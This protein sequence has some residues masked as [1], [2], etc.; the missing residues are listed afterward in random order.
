MN[1]H[2]NS[3]PG[4]SLVSV[5]GLSKIFNARGFLGKKRKIR[6]VDD[7][8]LEIPR[9]K[10]FGLVGESGCGKTTLSRCILYLETPSQGR[11]VIDGTDLSALS[12][13]ALRAI[14]RKM[15]IVFQDPNSALNPKMKIKNSISEGLE[16]YGWSP[17]QR[18]NRVC[19][20]LE[21]V[22]ISPDL[23]NRYP[24]EFSGGQRQRIVIARA[25]TMNPELLILDE[26][27]SN[28]DVSVQ[29]QIINLL[30]DLKKKFNMTYL[31][32]SH[33][34]NLTAYLSDYLAVM[35]QGKIVESGSIETVLTRP[36][37]PYTC[38]LFGS[39]PGFNHIALGG[40]FHGAAAVCSGDSA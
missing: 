22:G 24:H 18:E 16:N 1:S 28:L 20:L 13:R 6:A 17:P 38:R 36:V 29:A 4:A 2:F 12:G 23:R 10:I 21:T 27:V 5:R 34:L 35:Y 37:H 26:P 19:E 14:R 25:L 7:V 31:F 33:D 39:I 30:M 3:G 32:I 8:D 40:S 11:V 15:Q 9:G